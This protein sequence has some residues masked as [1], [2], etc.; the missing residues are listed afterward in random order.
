MDMKDV[1]EF[2]RRFIHHDCEARLASYTEPDAEAFQRKVDEVERFHAPEENIHSGFSRGEL[3]EQWHEMSG[4]MRE[5][6]VPRTLFMVKKFP[7]PEPDGLYRAYLS[8]GFKHSRKGYEWRL[9]LSAT[10]NGLRIM[11]IDRLCLNCM[12]SGQT[13]GDPCQECGGKGWQHASG[14][15]LEVLSQPVEVFRLQAP[16]HPVSLADYESA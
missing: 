8:G 5:K 6:V 15:R 3:S 13:A 4:K 7:Q 16:T 12:G 9:T 11:S 2:L 1:I 10:P 14:K